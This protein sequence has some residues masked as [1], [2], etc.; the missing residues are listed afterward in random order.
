MLLETHTDTAAEAIM[1]SAMD[2]AS[3]KLVWPACV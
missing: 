3:Q 1:S 2:S